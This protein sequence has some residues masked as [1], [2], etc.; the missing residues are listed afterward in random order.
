MEGAAATPPG[1]AT[2]ENFP[3]VEDTGRGNSEG[4][5]AGVGGTTPAGWVAEPAAGSEQASAPGGGASGAAGVGGEEGK[6]R[7]M[8]WQPKYLTVKAVFFLFY[9]SLGALMPYLPVYYHALGI[10]DR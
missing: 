7:K 5:G 10:G 4:G 1:T 8:K 9:S 6:V 3:S 2:P